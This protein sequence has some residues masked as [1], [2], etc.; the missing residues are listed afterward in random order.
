MKGKEFAKKHGFTLV[1]KKPLKIWDSK[2]GDKVHHRSM[3]VPM[4]ADL[5]GYVNCY[6]NADGL[7]LLVP[8]DKE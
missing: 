7:V 5:T 2:K 4:L 6:H 8:A 3:T 1:I